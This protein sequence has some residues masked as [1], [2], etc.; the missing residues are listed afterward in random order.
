MTISLVLDKG[1]K[2]IWCNNYMCDLWDSDKN[3]G[4]CMLVR[5]E[6]SSLRSDTLSLSERKE[7]FSHLTNIQ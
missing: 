4:H 7:L 6:K 3:G 5:C 2:M 1:V